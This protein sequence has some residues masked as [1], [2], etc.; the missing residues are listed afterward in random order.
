MAPRF[1]QMHLREAKMAPR[2]VWRWWSR[3]R[4]A[5]GSSSTASRRALERPR[6]R[7]VAGGIIG[8][9]SRALK[10]EL[11]AR[12]RQL[13]LGG[14]LRQTE[15]L[16][17]L[18]E[19]FSEPALRDDVW[20]W[21]KPRFDELVAKAKNLSF[22]SSQIFG[23]LGLFCDDAHADEVES[24]IAPRLDAIDGGRRAGAQAVEDI[25]LCAAKRKVQE[26]S[27][28]EFFSKKR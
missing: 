20:A 5:T 25:R 1:E 24:F 18:W 26:P 27:A 14:K 23:M 10:P 9:L 8:A 21:M 4:T 2:R 28:R 17:P 3:C 19:Q 7:T 6:T 16:Q 11:A 15:M 22:G 13:V 12:A